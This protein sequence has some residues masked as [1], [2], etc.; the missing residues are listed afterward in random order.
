MSDREFELALKALEMQAALETMNAS[1]A[2]LPTED[3]VSDSPAPVANSRGRRASV[4][5]SRRTSS[6]VGVRLAEADALVSGLSHLDDHEN[7]TES[8]TESEPE[9]DHTTCSTYMGVDPARMSD[10]QSATDEDLTDEDDEEN[11][12]EFDIVEVE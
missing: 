2:S 1:G 12:F 9:D 11:D 4:R 5:R 10:S 3:V 7:Q 6:S 8:E